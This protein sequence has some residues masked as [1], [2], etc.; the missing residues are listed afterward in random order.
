MPPTKDPFAFFNEKLLV[1]EVSIIS[2]C[3][4]ANLVLLV[5]PE[6]AMSLFRNEN[7][8]NKM[9]S[10]DPLSTSKL[11][12]VTW[13][14][15]GKEFVVGY[16]DGVVYKVDITYHDPR[17]SKC[18][19]PDPSENSEM[20]NSV[21]AL[22]WI[23]YEYRKKPLDIRGFDIDAFDIESALPVLSEEPPEEPVSH[24]PPRLRKKVQLPTK[25]L[26]SNELQT[27]LFIGNSNGDV[28]IILNGIYPIGSININ[29][30]NEDSNIMN[31]TVQQNISSL[32]LLTRSKIE[33]DDELMLQE[34]DTRFLEDRKEQVFSI[35]KIQR[36]LNYL[37]EYARINMDVLK[38]H[39]ASYTKLT[40]SVS[41][42]AS[43]SILSHN[44]QA[45]AMPEV[46][47]TGTLA[48]GSVTETLQE[49]FIESLTSAHIRTW[50]TQTTHGHQN[51]LKIVCEHLL[52]AAERIQLE[53]SKLLG[54]SLWTQRYS[55]FLETASV[56]RCINSVIKLVS[57]IH[58]FTKDLNELIT[59]FQAFVKWITVVS[60][61]VTDPNSVEYQ[62]ESSLCEDPELVLKFLNTDFI[63]DSLAKYFISESNQMTLIEMMSDVKTCCDQM[64]EKPSGTIS[65]KIRLTSKHYFKL[66]DFPILNQPTHNVISYT[67]NEVGDTQRSYYAFIHNNSNSK[68][69]IVKSGF[70]GKRAILDY[71]LY[72]TC[73]TITDVAFFDDKELGVCIQQ[74]ENNSLL[75][76]ILLEDVNFRS[77]A[78]SKFI[79]EELKASRSQTLNNMI[80]IKLGCNGLPRRRIMSIVASNSLM[81]VLSMD[82][83]EVEDMS[84]EED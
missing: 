62:N 69:I 72:D 55:D 81:R 12:V 84:S 57:Q 22:V 14:P 65:K 26:V 64:L 56:E 78:G 17:T 66:Q 30:E 10:L 34:I 38:R 42:K 8:V 31:I 7:V 41:Q 73:G 51:S 50:E 48:I 24:L 49:F 15:N 40:R 25:P 23:N 33:N 39:H 2:W 52:P 19:P 58:L 74:D 45:T 47:L 70:G 28:H 44:A 27:L 63:I 35:S 46:E 16:E 68:L 82:E 83:E 43:N 71:A 79:S 13:K 80:G 77:L 9:W 18:W 20:P 75:S 37:L 4:T 5:S 11:N 67:T 29:M 76:T 32:L 1:D 59:S 3:P 61:K 21:T 54:Y 60:Q 36:K 6:G 53:L